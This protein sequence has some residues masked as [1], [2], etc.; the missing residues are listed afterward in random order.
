[1]TNPRFLLLQVRN[2]GDPMAAQEIRCFARSLPCT[3]SCIEVF[4]LLS[5][6]PSKSAL[7]RADVVLLGGSGEY[8]VVR[9]GPWLSGA[10]DTMVDLYA[11]GRPTFASCWGFQAMAKALG[12]TVVTLSLIHI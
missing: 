11:E 8:S 7:K 9:G 3:P 10:L 2:P 6:V 1:M 12:G 5:G 4:D